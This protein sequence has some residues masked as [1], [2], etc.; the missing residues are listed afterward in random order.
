MVTLIQWASEQLRGKPTMAKLAVANGEGR[1]TLR[2]LRIFQ[3]Q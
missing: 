2:F 1:E 3:Q